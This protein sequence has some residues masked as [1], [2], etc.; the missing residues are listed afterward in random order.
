MAKLELLVSPPGTGKTTYCID[1]FRKEIL[2][3]PGG[4]DS[5]AYFVLPNREHAGRIQHLVL[6]KDVPGLFNVHIMTIQE[7]GLGLL[8]GSQPPKPSESLRRS[9]LRRLLEDASLPLP[10]FSGVRDLPVFYELLS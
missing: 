9:I 2:K 8:G 7:L 1:L 10:T 5:R 3:S 6:K 4:L